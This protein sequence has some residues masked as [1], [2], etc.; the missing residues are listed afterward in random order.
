MPSGQSDPVLYVD[1]QKTK[2]KLQH[3]TFLLTIS[4]RWSLLLVTAPNKIDTKSSKCTVQA[5]IAQSIIFKMTDGNV[6]SYSY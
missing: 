6:I 5:K 2:F 3:L 1:L 4:C